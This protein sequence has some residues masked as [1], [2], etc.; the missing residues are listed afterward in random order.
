MSNGN[1]QWDGGVALLVDFENLVLS[2]GGRREVDC[3]ALLRLAAG[4]G[5]VCR[6]NLY[7]DWRT[8]T[9]RGY[10]DDLFGLG[11]EFVQVLGRRRGRVRKNAVDIRMAVDA[12][13]LVHNMPWIDVYVLVTG[14]RDFVYLVQAL[15]REGK[16]VVG[17][18]PEDGASAELA[19]T[20]DRFLYYE[21]IA[22]RA[23]P[24][25]GTAGGGG[26]MRALARSGRVAGPAVRRAL[27]FL[28]GTRRGGLC[29]PPVGDSP[30]G[31]YGADRGDAP[32]AD[33]ARSPRGKGWAWF[34][35]AREQ[36]ESGAV[37]VNADGGWLHRI[38]GEAYVVVPDC[39]EEHAALEGVA[40][41]TVK[42]RVA[43]LGRHRSRRSH[44]GR[45]DLFPA[46]LGDGRKV[47]GMLFQGELLW[48]DDD[49]EDGPARL[50]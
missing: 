36:V 47:H 6:A 18:A 24:R 17:V 41:K 43:K 45:A 30:G 42:N 33:A 46:V 38:G 14:D 39:F 29:R 40:P 26:V 15:Q 25:P 11:F 21:A 10:P 22:W 7:A 8:R 12:M 23:G 50:V 16:R 1:E 13:A 9:M 5:P 28:G 37:V 32:P 4:Y 49:P 44:G 31:A 2:G 35:W 27:G 20:C 34:E 3:G 48:G 19:A